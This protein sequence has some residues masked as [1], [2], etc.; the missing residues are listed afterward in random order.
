MSVREAMSTDV[1]T[2]GPGHTLRD[3]SRA[4]RDRHVGACVVVDPGGV[5]VGILTER[6]VLLALAEGADPDAET[7]SARLTPDIVYAAPGWSLEQAAEAMLR[8]GFRH[9]VV[10]DEG[11]VS[12]ML[13]LRGIPSAAE[14]VMIARDI[15]LAELTGGR[16]HV[17]H[18][19]TEGSVRL[20]AQA[21]ERGIRVTA[22]TC[23][24]YFSI[25]E[26]AV[27]GYNTNAKV[28]PPLR[29]AKDVA[30]IKEGLRNG[31]IDVIATD[32]APHHRD[33]KLLEFDK[34]LSGISGL[35]TAFALSLRLVDEGVLTMST[36]VEKMAWNPVKILGM[37]KG[38]LKAGA[39]ADVVIV[40]ASKEFIVEPVAFASKG[41]NTPF[42]GWRLK[43]AAV[44]VIVKEKILEV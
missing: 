10:L 41:R 15:A 9:L 37:Q 26:D 36:L 12:G 33:E 18:V 22:E 6:D 29:T 4:M 16:L 34:A 44:K 11:E 20:I 31:T 17:A 7:A 13:G 40:D 19:S 30:A 28:N 25:T 32:H 8:G 27:M 43:G 3:C 14:E 35:E 38:T 39:D 42:G 5:G 23:P 2:V 1:L 21:K 24:H